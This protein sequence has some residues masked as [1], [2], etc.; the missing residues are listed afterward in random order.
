MGADAGCSGSSADSGAGGIHTTQ[1]W[2]VLTQRAGVGALMW[3]LAK[4][5]TGA[6]MQHAGE[7]THHTGPG[8]LTQ[9]AGHRGRGG[10]INFKSEPSNS[11]LG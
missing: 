6:L 11:L 4:H 3:V 9:D 1:A 7:L 8:A 2:G 10:T 5:T